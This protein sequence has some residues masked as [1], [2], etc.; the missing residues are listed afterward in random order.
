MKIG[1][2]GLGIMGKPMSKNLV[3]AGY[4]LIVYDRNQAAAHEVAECGAQ[5]AFSTAEVA[6]VSEPP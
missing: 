1:F 6:A 5:E 4:D 2:I 3:K